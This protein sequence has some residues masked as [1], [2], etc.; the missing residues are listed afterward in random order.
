MVPD[1]TMPWR[2]IVQDVGLSALEL[3]TVADVA[4]LLR[5]SKPTVWR[6]IYSG[7]LESVKVGRSRRVE[8]KAV[9]DYL[10]R[11]AGRT[12]ADAA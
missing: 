10:D 5:V 7:E 1:S 9:R 4:K 11:C 12:P 3:L 6:R 8:A 2:S